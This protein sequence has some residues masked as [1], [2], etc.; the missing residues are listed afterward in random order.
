MSVLQSHNELIQAENKRRLAEQAVAQAKKPSI[1]AAPKPE[2]SDLDD[3]RSRAAHELGVIGEPTIPQLLLLLKDADPNIRRWAAGAFASMGDSGK[4]AVPELKML[5]QDSNALVRSMAAIALGSVGVEVAG[6]V[7]LLEE[8]SH[9]DPDPD[10]RKAASEALDYLYHVVPAKI[11]KVV[12]V[13]DRLGIAPKDVTQ[14]VSRTIAIVVPNQQGV[15]S[16]PWKDYVTSVKE[17]E[18][19][20]GYDFFANLPKEVQQAIEAKVN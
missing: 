19:L 11:W 15:K 3:V 14:K 10:V 16:K 6:T 5:L 9:N 20:T 18:K 17:V 12:L 13:I 4:T 7:A 8:V 1:A 2:P